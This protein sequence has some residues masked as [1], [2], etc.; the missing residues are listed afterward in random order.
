MVE[1]NISIMAAGNLKG[2]LPRDFEY[3]FLDLSYV[4]SSYGK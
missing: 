1:L 4:C 2:L 3:I